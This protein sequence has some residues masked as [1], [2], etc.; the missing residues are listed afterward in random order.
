MRVCENGHEYHDDIG[1]TCPICSQTWALPYEGKTPEA[2]LPDGIDYARRVRLEPGDV[3]VLFCETPLPRSAQETFR[4][5]M[6]AAFPDNGVL[7]LHGSGLRLAV[8]GADS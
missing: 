1:E 4:S 2:I 8:L 6:Q 3:L 7:I 5:Q